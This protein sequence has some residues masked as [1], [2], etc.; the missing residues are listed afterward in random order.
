M[1]VISNPHTLIIK[2][3]VT[4]TFGNVI[5]IVLFHYCVAAD[6]GMF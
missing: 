4:P 6:F 3:I 5:Y 2:I 1:H